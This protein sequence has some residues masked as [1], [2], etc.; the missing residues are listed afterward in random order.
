M[1]GGNECYRNQGGSGTLWGGWS[2]L[3][4]RVVWV[5]A[6]RQSSHHKGATAEVCHL[7]GNNNQDEG[8]SRQRKCQ[9]GQAGLPPRSVNH[10]KEFAF[11]LRIGTQVGLPDLANGEIAN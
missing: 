9:T 7:L 1:L 3:L 4:N 2:A 6:G 5:A 11:I 8:E 10:S